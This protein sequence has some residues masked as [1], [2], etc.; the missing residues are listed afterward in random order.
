MYHSEKELH[1]LQFYCK[2]ETHPTAPNIKVESGLENSDALEGR[3]NGRFSES[4]F[5]ADITYR[6]RPS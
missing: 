4:T 1:K 2:K 3:Y 5:W 6:A